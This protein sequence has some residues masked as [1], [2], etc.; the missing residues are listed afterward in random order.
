MSVIKK[1]LN[2]TLF[3]ICG[4]TTLYYLHQ[5]DYSLS[6]IGIVRF[7]RVGHTAVATI[8]DYKLSLLG[9]DSESADYKERIWQCH[10]RGADRLLHLARRNGGVFIKVGQHIASLQY[11]LPEPYTST[12]SILHSKAPESSLDDMKTVFYRSLHKNF[13]DVFDEFDPRPCGAASLAQ[14][15][16]A[17]LK[18]SDEYVAVK[19]QHLH[20]KDRSFVDM[21]TMEFF[22]NIASF[23]FP[24]LKLK[25]LVRETKLNL[26]QELDFLHEAA[27]ADKVR[28]MFSHMR[29]V[30]IPKIHYNYSSDKVLTM[31]FCEGGQ[32]NDLDYFQVH[33]LDRH[34]ICRLLGA[35]YSEMIFRRGYIH[36]D[37]HPGNV[38]VRRSA[39]TGREEIVLLD[40][41]LYCTLPD[42][43]RIDYAKLWLALMKPDQDEIRR[44]CERMN[45]GQN[46]GLFACIVTMRSWK[47]VTAGI[48]RTEI[49]D[50][51]RSHIKEYATG[52]IPQ[53]S[54]VLDSIPRQ[55]LLILKTNDLLRSIAF[56]LKT[57]HRLDSFSEMTKHCT[58][59]VYHHSIAATQS[60]LSKLRLYLA[61]YVLLVKINIFEV[62]LIVNGL[63]TARQRHLTV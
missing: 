8:V 3:G 43:L 14:V 50:R 32:I 11:L 54:M 47:S 7:A 56:K 6:H 27:N 9:L 17:K 62:F 1:F 15:H 40:H 45:I 39:I 30:K 31:E 33:Q 19:I 23:V 55:M 49:D 29:F 53:I 48:A 59:A 18:S 42:E 12:L 57:E 5:N 25:W 37:P 38:L 61:M 4:S 46:Y 36:S 34:K 16:R 60:L 10:Q 20:V 52:L 24:E 13:D 26:P 28:R 51:E 44:V 21:A 58:R 35:L 22:V 41:G 2:F 63:F